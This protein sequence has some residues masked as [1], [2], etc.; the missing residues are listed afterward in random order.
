MLVSRVELN[1]YT[2]FHFMFDSSDV[3][4]LWFRRRIV[5]AGKID[6]YIYC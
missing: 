3:D 1:Y 4:N 5:C 6:R 2:K